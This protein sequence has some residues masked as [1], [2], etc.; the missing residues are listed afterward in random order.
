MTIWTCFVFLFW[1][2][3]NK[4]RKI[5]KTKTKKHM[6]K[7]KPESQHVIEVT[8]ISPKSLRYLWF[9][10]QL[11]LCLWQKAENYSSVC[12]ALSFKQS[13]SFPHSCSTDYVLYF[14]IKSLC[15]CTWTPLPMLSWFSVRNDP[16]VTVL[17]S[18]V[19]TINHRFD[20]PNRF[21]TCKD[22]FTAEVFFKSILPVDQAEQE[23]KN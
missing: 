23:D 3:Q 16:S 21:L 7:G 1:K 5:W 6:S 10:K 9:H 12:S 4:R 2:K 13:S 18:A 8:S 14:A 20:A 11:V 22:F 19:L 17:A 15:L